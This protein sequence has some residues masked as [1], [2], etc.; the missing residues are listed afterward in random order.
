MINKRFEQFE[1]GDRK[2][3]EGDFK[4][5]LRM[6]KELFIFILMLIPYS[7]ALIFYLVTLNAQKINDYLSKIFIEP[8]KLIDEFFKWFFQAKYTAS[9][10]IF[11]ILMFVV[12]FIFLMDHMQTL[13]VHPLHIF[14]GNY[15]SM[16]SSIFLHA[17][18]THLLSNLL[19]LMIFG[20]IV[21][22]HFGYKMLFLFFFSGLIANIVSNLIAYSLGDYFYSLGASGGIAG[23][24]MFAVLMEPFAL[25]SIFLLPL[26][27]F[28]I[29][30][31]LIFLDIIGLTNSS[32]TNHLAHLGGYSAL[33]V[34]FFFL[35]YRQKRKILL[36]LMINIAMLI[37][38]Y[39]LIKYFKINLGLDF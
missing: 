34:L 36:G 16:I 7:L 24:I 8:F 29:G 33:L 17:D 9:L 23:I 20:R 12:E 2:E 15:I 39:I 31:F 26:P 4:I 35:E 14:E 1:L 18:I 22:R 19:A 10:V 27:I 3:I 21:E 28:L 32:Q 5:F 11:L 6:L 37:I 13:M 38:F 30:W 25:T